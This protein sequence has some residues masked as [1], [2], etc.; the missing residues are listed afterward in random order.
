MDRQRALL[1]AL[2]GGGALVTLSYCYLRPAALRAPPPLIDEPEEK[3]RQRERQGE[4]AQAKTG[5]LCTAAQAG[6]VSLVRDLL[7]S[8]ADPNDAGE[9]NRAALAH[10]AANGREGCVTALL[11]AGS[12]LPPRMEPDGAASFT[13][14]PIGYIESPYLQKNGT[15][16][17]PGLSAA[18][19]RLR[20]LWGTNREAALSGITSYSH[21]WLVWVFDQNG[22]DAVRA[23]ARPPRLG[24]ERTGVFACRTPHRPNPIGLSLVTLERLDGDVL[25]LSGADLVDGTAI[26]DIKPY[27]PYSDAWPQ[28]ATPEVQVRTASFASTSGAAEALLEVEFSPQARADLQNA[29]ATAHGKGDA[30]HARSLRF[31]RGKAAE[32]EAVFTQALGTDTRSNYHKSKN[33]AGRPYRMNLDG[34]D[35]VCD[36]DDALHKVTVRHVELIGD[37]TIRFKEN[38]KRLRAQSDQYAQQRQQRQEERRRD[39]QAHKEELAA[40]RRPPKDRGPDESGSD[41]ATGIS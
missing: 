34:L 1:P 4:Q 16:R 5:E 41:G 9:G 24:G 28:L 12:A 21:V 17:Q 15:P 37:P 18:P 29:C 10:A 14:A 6:D 27:V 35:A 20:L 19:S 33:C 36:F 30:V 13:F 22:G 38:E 39:R 3:Q 40:K 11:G 23:K 32:A 31:F 26:L 25:E 2:A 8:G 7:M